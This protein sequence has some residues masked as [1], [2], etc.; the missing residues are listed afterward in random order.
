MLEPIAWIAAL[1]A[2]GGGDGA[3]AAPDEWAS[4][5]SELAA[6][7]QASADARPETLHLGGVMRV[8]IGWG[9]FDFDQT[10]RLDPNEQD[11]LFTELL[12]VQP[13]LIWSATEDLWGTIWLQ[14]ASG[15][16]ELERA[17]ADQRIAGE[18][19]KARLGLFG[20]PLF[21]EWE[22]PHNRYFFFDLAWPT[23]VTGTNQAGLQLY[24]GAGAVSWWAVAQNGSDGVADDLLATGRI[25][26]DLAGNGLP[27]CEG[28]IAATE[29]PMMTVAA[30][31]EDEGA[32]GQ[33]VG[34]AGEVHYVLAPFS[35]AGEI[36]SLGEDIGDATPWSATA[37]WVLEPERW[38]IGVRYD[39]F[40]NQV[41]MQRWT[42]GVNNYY[43]GAGVE[44]H[45]LKWTL[46]GGVYDGDSSNQNGAFLQFG[47]TFAF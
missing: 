44:A 7:A 39:S 6:L 3:T 33:G 45:D 36:V 19:L 21:R 9:D 46:D 38:E 35:L 26:V 23:R 29:Q 28:A 8:E 5:D 47:L 43:G 17:F 25:S 34:V 22:L 42:F 18:Y 32:V 12:D 13:I 24:G 16:V 40:D 1:L 30:A 20:Q 10:G 11:L 41:G 27:D 31:I 15:S 37:T 4:L 14:A 2:F